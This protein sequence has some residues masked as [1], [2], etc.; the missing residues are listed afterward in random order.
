MEV[1]GVGGG[2]ERGVGGQVECSVVAG[3]HRVPISF[4][5]GHRSQGW[6]RT[7]AQHQLAL[8][9]PNPNNIDLII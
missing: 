6:A 3:Q 2:G 4:L 7:H 5:R 1:D 9:Q 8:I